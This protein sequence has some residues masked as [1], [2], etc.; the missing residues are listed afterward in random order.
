VFLNQRGAE[1][2]FSTPSAPPRPIHSNLS[3]SFEASWYPR[4]TSA[5][6]QHNKIIFKASAGGGK[7]S[8]GDW[9]WGISCDEVY[10]SR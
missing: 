5:P 1:F 7:F 9:T 3:P 2:S 6:A 8:L 10:G 4:K